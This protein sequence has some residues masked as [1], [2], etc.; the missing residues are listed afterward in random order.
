ML[1]LIFNSNTRAGEQNKQ[2]RKALLKSLEEKFL[3]S[4]ISTLHD[5]PCL[6]EHISQGLTLQLLYCT[7]VLVC[8]QLRKR[9]QREAAA[10]LGA[11][12]NYG[13]VRR[14]GRFASTRTRWLG[15]LRAERR[16]ASRCSGR[17]CWHT[18]RCARFALYE[19]MNPWYIDCGTIEFPLLIILLVCNE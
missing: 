1:L 17:I 7:Y 4:G 16:R 5:I 11:H 9:K 13:N 3:L 14:L 12:N 8:R 6:L 19:G 15:W 2:S 18:C 10:K